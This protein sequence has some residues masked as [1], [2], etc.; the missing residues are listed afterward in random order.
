MTDSLPHTRLKVGDW[1]LYGPTN[2]VA[3]IMAIAKDGEDVWWV[4]LELPGQIIHRQ[5]EYINELNKPKQKFQV[6]QRLEF[7]SGSLF[8][9]YLTVVHCHCL[10]GKFYYMVEGVLR[11]PEHTEVMV[12]GEEKLKIAQGTVEKRN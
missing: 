11:E 8:Y 7:A 12:V 9:K 1:V 3:K 2:Y 5:L 6:G 4:M 10:N